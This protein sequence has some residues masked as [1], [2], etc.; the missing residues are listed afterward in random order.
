M[1]SRRHAGR[2][3][4]CLISVS[5]T[6]AVWAE[7]TATIGPTTPPPPPP[8]TAPA[9]RDVLAGK[10]PLRILVATRKTMLAWRGDGSVKVVSLADGTSLYTAKPNE[11]VG[12]TRATDQT[13]WLRQNGK[14]FCAA[15]SVLRLESEK[16]IRLWTPSPDAWA[17]YAAKVIL[18]P[19][20]DGTFS[21]ALE[22]PLEEYVRNV[23]PVEMPSTFHPQAL[24][25]QAII[26][27]TY[28][29]CKL[30]RHVDLGAD[31]CAG[32]H[33]QVCG[34]ASQRSTATDDAVRATRGLVLLS[35][36]KLTE[37]YYHATCGGA[38]DD[39]G[40]VWGPEYARSY[41][42]GRLDAD[43]SRP[44]SVV[45]MKDV[46]ANGG[47]YCKASSSFRWVTQFSAAQVDALVSANLAK[48]T[49][50]ATV[51]IR[52]VTKLQVEERTPFGRVASLRVEG[53]GVSVLVM[54]D[55]VRWLFGSGQPG[56]DGLFSTLFDLTATRDA[57]GAIS[58]YV[59][60]GAGRG[61]GLGLCQWGADGRARAGQT[62]R[63]IVRAYYPGTR[64]SDERD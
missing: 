10:A 39:A 23:V 2:F 61:H 64:L 37:P 15:P 54:G 11:Q 47:A 3:L 19:I 28:A 53:D 29:L 25:A 7:P 51:Q 13:C 40:Y 45:K 17:T 16:P 8:Y 38:T 60:R 34:E 52:Q 50:D 62:Y 35:D 33:C 59:L 22:M 32:E 12:L 9:Y 57:A 5:A 26:A 58:G 24:R 55:R 43:G 31:L 20:P 56:P 1:I 49:G 48:V 36:G 6:L 46:L 18:T 30:G 41:L 63:E 21:I 42:I 4:A 14:N 27:R 44:A